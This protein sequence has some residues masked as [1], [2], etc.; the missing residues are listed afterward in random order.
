MSMTT[1]LPRWYG[2]VHKTRPMGW[3]TCVTYSY[4]SYLG[5]VQ[6]VLDHRRDYIL[7]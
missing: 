7:A 4:C 1:S 2:C 5:V 3:C 6:I